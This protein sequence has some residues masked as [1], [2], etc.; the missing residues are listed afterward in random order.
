MRVAS[1][2][3]ENLDEMRRTKDGSFCVKCEQNVVDLRRVPEKRA[4]A[5]ISELKAAGDGL[6]CVRV[7]ATRDGVPVFQ[8]DPSRFGRLTLPIAL[9]GSLAA[10]TPSSGAM[11]QR[12]TP[13]AVVVDHAGQTNGTSARGTAPLTTVIATPRTTPNTSNVSY[14]TD[15]VEMAGGLG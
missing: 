3:T 2:C 9:A 14:P 10:C 8:K 11:E 1:P 5:V 4:L 7:R 13:I 15:I 6:V 12:T